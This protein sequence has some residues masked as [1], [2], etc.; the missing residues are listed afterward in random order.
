LYQRLKECQKEGAAGIPPNEL[1]VYMRQAASAIDYLNAPQHDLGGKKVSILHRDIKP[2]NILIAAKTAKV[3]D[4]GLAKVME[5]LTAAVNRNTGGLTL[6]YAAPELMTGAVSRWTDQYALAIT[7][8]H[9]RTG[10]LPF[11]QGAAIHEAALAD[12]HGN[13]QCPGS[14]AHRGVIG[15]SRDRAASPVPGS[16]SPGVFGHRVHGSESSGSA[17]RGDDCSL[18]TGAARV[19]DGTTRR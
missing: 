15:H 16:G 1:I 6:S 4:F 12:M 10:K 7:Y 9:L 13:D 19:S 11:P 17:G 8:Y 3:G 5:G 14:G 18:R 2:E